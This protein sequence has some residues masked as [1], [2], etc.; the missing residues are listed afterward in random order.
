MTTS[1]LLVFLL[2]VGMQKSTVDSLL[3]S[4]WTKAE[5]QPAP[6]VGDAQFYRRL[7][8]DLIGRIPSKAELDAYLRKPDPGTAVNALLES[9]EFSR[10]WSEVWAATL[11][12]YRRNRGREG[13][14]TWLERQFDG[15]QPF[16]AI[17]SSLII[18]K[19][20]GTDNFLHIARLD[21]A[22]KVSQVFLGIRLDCAR[23][24]DH[25]FDRWT[26]DDFLGMNRFFEV[27]ER[28]LFGGGA[29]DGRNNKPRFLNGAEPV[30]R[31][32]R[33]EFTLYM[34][35]SRAFAQNTANRLWY[36]FMGRGIVHPPDDFN[37]KHKPSVPALLE[38]LAETVRKSDWDLRVL[39][40]EI[41]TSE[42]YRRSSVRGEPDPKRERLFAYRALKPLTAEQLYDSLSTALGRPS[43]ARQDHVRAFTTGTVDADYTN[44]WDYR[45]SV[46]QLMKKLSSRQ[47]VPDV[48]VE[49][50][51]LRI[52]SRKPTPRERELCRERSTD[53][54]VFALVN[55]S[56]FFWNH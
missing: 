11:V 56:E 31:K 18:A 45:E 54:I 38:H 43:L 15:N 25:P 48:S 42:A 51:Y 1:S 26:Q 53:D 4:A 10:F 23:C 36:H 5:V 37:R 12:G 55:S 24:H 41:C 9:K 16:D 28:D 30:T 50:L 8:L 3:E 20:N 7:S 47:A 49:E 29:S 17:A 46:Q 13:L 39:I 40:R 33:D 32:W 52:L 27:D 22:V 35:R 14:R 44:A 6:L 34:K 2:A 19:E 21:P